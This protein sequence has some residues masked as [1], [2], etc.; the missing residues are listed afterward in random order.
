[1]EFL[2]FTL[3]C[4]YGEQKSWK[5]DL[6]KDKY[7]YLEAIHKERYDNDDLQVAVQTPD[8]QMFG[9]IPSQFLWTKIP[10]KPNQGRSI[11][12]YHSSIPFIN[13]Q[14]HELLFDIIYHHSKQ[15]NIVQSNLL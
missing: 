6:D 12:H 5:L 11:N 15:F 3:H 10:K 4:R 8:G 9:P 1:M 14:Y 2:Y 7:Y 13:I